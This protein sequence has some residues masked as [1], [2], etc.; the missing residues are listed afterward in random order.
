MSAALVLGCA[1]GGMGEPLRPTVVLSLALLALAASITRAARAFGL[2]LAPGG[3][4]LVWLVLVACL[5]ATRAA[6]VARTTDAGFGPRSSGAGGFLERGRWEEQRRTGDLAWGRLDGLGPQLVLPTGTVAAGEELAI[7]GLGR[8]IRR[9]RGF[10]ATGLEP[11]PAAPIARIELEIDEVLRVAPAPCTAGELLL[12]PLELLRTAGLERLRS[13]ED[14]DTRTLVSALVFGDSSDLPSALA[15]LFSRTGARHLLA[16]SGMHVALVAWWIVRPGCRWFFSGA[17]PWTR[18]RLAA[19]CLGEASIV[20]LLVGVWGSQAPVTRAAVAWAA[21][22]LAPLFPAAHPLLARAGRRPDPLTLLALATL[23]E[24]LGDP[25]AVR[26]V[27]MQLSYAATLGLI[28]GYGRMRVAL[29]RLCFGTEDPLALGGILHRGPAFLRIALGKLT[30]VVLGSLAASAVACLATL[31]VAWCTFGECTWAALPATL[32]SL[33]LMLALMLGGALLL[34]LRFRSEALETGLGFL[35]RAW[36]ALLSAL[37]ALPGTPSP[38]PERPAAWIAL[39]GCGWLVWLAGGTRGRRLL[40]RAVAL[41]TGATLLPWSLDPLHVE[42]RALDVGHGSSVHVRLPG[43][44]DWMFDAGSLDR[45][46]LAREAI[47]PTLRRFEVSE[48]T[49]LASHEHLDHAGALG[50]IAE[51]WPV[52]AWIGAGAAHPFVRAPHASESYDLAEGALEIGAGSFLRIQVLRGWEGP[53]N[54]GSRAVLLDAGGERALLLG[55]AEGPGLAALLASGRIQGPMRM[56]LAPHH[57]SFSPLFHDL[58]ETTRPEEVWVSAAGEPPIG[59]E[60]SRRGIRWRWTGR[61]G[62]LSLELAARRSP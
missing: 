37:D 35:T 18:G 61:D 27:S 7:L 1:W 14:P 52:E 40:A 29:Q 5:G 8:S 48:L 62:P 22:S 49:V 13:I 24:C 31:P 28:L 47:G 50:W 56:V 51:R 38:L 53:G 2:V 46:G 39:A 12:E 15:E 26:D 59:A 4:P 34:V 44:R 57:G 58:L 9:A 6:G 16:L 36:I 19:A 10:D 43:A 33:P 42:I 23:V 3:L 21:A 25:L 54:E 20:L 11:A 17:W 32:L 55:D 41:L 45:P 30:A 60:L